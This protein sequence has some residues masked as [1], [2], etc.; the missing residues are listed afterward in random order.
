MKSNQSRN[1]DCNEKISIQPRKSSQVRTSKKFQLWNVQ[2][3]EYSNNSTGQSQCERTSVQSGS[4]GKTNK[5]IVTRGALPTR[6]N[7][8]NACKPVP[9]NDCN[10]YGRD[11]NVID[12]VINRDRAAS[13]PQRSR[14]IHE[15]MRS[16]CCLRAIFDFIRQ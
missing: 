5:G 13:S 9:H 11:R 12:D 16:F 15:S 1:H 14:F 8:R 2:M 10:R 4:N 7:A 6:G 3:T